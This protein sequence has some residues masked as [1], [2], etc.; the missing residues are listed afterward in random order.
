MQ[1]NKLFTTVCGIALTI[2][3]ISICPAW[4]ELKITKNDD[5]TET[6]F[7]TNT[8]TSTV[9]RDGVILSQTQEVKTQVGLTGGPNPK[10]VYQTTTTTMDY[11]T[12]ITTS[13]SLKDDGS[14]TVT[15]QDQKTGKV[16]ITETKPDK[17]TRVR[18]NENGVIT[19]TETNAKDGKTTVTTQDQ[20]KGTT[21]TVTTDGDNVTTHTLYDDGTTSVER[22]NIVKNDDGTTQTI[23]EKNNRDGTS[24]LDITSSDGSY[25]S[26]QKMNEDGEVISHEIEEKDPE[27]METLNY[28]TKDEGGNT[29]EYKKNSDGSS[30]RTEIKDGVKTETSYKRNSE[31]Y[32]EET[33]KITEEDGI[34]LF[35]KDDVVQTKTVFGENGRP[36][37]K[38][39]EKVNQGGLLTGDSV[40]TKTTTYDEDG[41]ID[42]I[43]E[44]DKDTGEVKETKYT[45]NDRGGTQTETVHKDEDGNVLSETTVFDDSNGYKQISVYDPETKTTKTIHTSDHGATK[46][47]EETSYSDEN[48]N[49]VVEIK[50]PDGSTSKSSREVVQ[51]L[52]N[53]GRMHPEELYVTERSDSSGNVTTIKENADGTKATTEIKRADGSQYAK[54]ETPTGVQ[55]VEMSPTGEVTAT[56]TTKRFENGVEVGHNKEVRVGGKVVASETVAEDPNTGDVTTIGYDQRTGTSVNSIERFD[57]SSETSTVVTDPNDPTKILTKETVKKDKSGATEREFKNEKTGEYSNTTKDKNGN[58]LK[59]DSKTINPDGS[60]TTKK[61]DE[62]GGTKDENGNIVKAEVVTELKDANGNVISSSKESAVEDPSGNTI[63]KAEKTGTDAHGNKVT[64][65]QA[66]VLGAD[67]NPLSKTEGTKT[68]SPDGIT[69]EKT[70]TTN[71]ETGTTT[72]TVADKNPD[73]SSSEIKT[74]TDQNGAVLE[75]TETQVSKDK[76]KI[77][78]KTTIDPVTKKQTITQIRK[79]ANDN[80]IGED[81][82]VINTD[83]TSTITYHDGSVVNL[84]ASGVATKDFKNSLF[85]E[86]KYKGYTW[87][88]LVDNDYGNVGEMMD[89]RTPGALGGTTL[90]KNPSGSKF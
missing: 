40:V 7:D 43:V 6:V 37:K 30:T 49:P 55:E 46:V 90:K 22:K 13:T 19:T 72:K 53:D 69:H 3:M 16:T 5:G 41:G 87:H 65:T 36:I 15:T 31:G 81:V 70:T 25:T 52:G 73:G 86:G 89:D 10:P 29:I 42:T 21:T 2:S 50:Y 26:K 84:G 68:E 4:A 14:K 58:T 79:D 76:T 71:V 38:V 45:Y 57:G 20:K 17:S 83:G 85:K 66:A 9:R 67:G 35:A 1:N 78:T 56:E 61:I 18:T 8:N 47:K 88:G 33:I 24:E 77:I 59:E 11:Q 60:T 48:G 39:E 63:I 64:T 28:S 27:T 82:Q 75:K 51:R 12:G 23:I 44:E 62:T 54:T 74:V 34:G 80:I 32:M